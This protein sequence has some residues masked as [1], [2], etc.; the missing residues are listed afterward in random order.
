MSPPLFWVDEAPGAGSVM[1]KQERVAP[2]TC[3]RSQRSFCTGVATA[4]IKWMLPSSGAWMLSAVG[5]S[6]E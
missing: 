2:A 1:A 6:Q 4:S 3:G 5:P